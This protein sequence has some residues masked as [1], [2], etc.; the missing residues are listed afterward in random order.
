MTT[1]LEIL[2]EGLTCD[3]NLAI[4]AQKLN[5]KFTPESPARFGQRCFENDGILDEYEFFMSNEQVNDRLLSWFGTFSE[6]LREMPQLQ[7]WEAAYESANDDVE[8]CD[9]VQS[10]PLTLPRL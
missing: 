7:E 10:N 5:G 3:F 9:S 2:S 8:W 1:L 4:Y 6:G